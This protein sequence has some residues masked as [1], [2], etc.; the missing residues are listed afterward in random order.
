MFLEDRKKK[1]TEPGL[2]FSN[3][4]FLIPIC[5]IILCHRNQL[6]NSK[7]NDSDNIGDMAGTTTIKSLHRV[8]KYIEKLILQPINC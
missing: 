6:N 1:L 4:N 5:W 7:W 3:S 8:G 2:I